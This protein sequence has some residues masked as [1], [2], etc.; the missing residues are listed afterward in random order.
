MLWQSFKGKNYFYS[1][2]THFVV[3]GGSQK[4]QFMFEKLE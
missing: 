2:L 1:F 3:V 4:N